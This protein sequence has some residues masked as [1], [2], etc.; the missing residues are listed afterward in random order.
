LSGPV[1]LL[2]GRALAAEAAIARA[3]QATNV[4]AA[5]GSIRVRHPLG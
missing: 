4:V 1:I 3:A 5:E 2:I